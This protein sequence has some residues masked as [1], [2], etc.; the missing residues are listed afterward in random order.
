MPEICPK[1]GK[2]TLDDCNRGYKKCYIDGC[3]MRVYPDGSKSFLRHDK[4]KIRRIKCYDD[5]E[6]IMTEFNYN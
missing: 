6:E 1:C 4:D 3:S 2:R 5:K